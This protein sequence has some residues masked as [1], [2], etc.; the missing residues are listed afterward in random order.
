MSQKVN[1][2]EFVK[3]LQ[4]CLDT[5]CG[6]I[7]GSKG[8]DPKKW[9]KD[10]WWFTQ[11]EGTQREKALYW[12][13]HA[14]RVFDCNGL[15]EGY[16]EDC[17]GIDI[18]SKA[19]YNYSQW[20]ADCHGSDMS[21]LPKVPG[22]A[23]FIHSNSS[24]YITHVGYL[25]KPVSADKPNGDWYVIE[26]RGVMYGVVR[27]KL[28]QRGWNRWG[29]MLQYMDYG[30]VSVPERELGAR[31]LK[32]GMTGTDVRTL[33]SLLLELGYE[34]PRY[35][36]DGQYGSETVNAVKAFQKWAGLSA[37][38]E[39]GPDTHKALMLAIN[40]L[41]ADEDGSSPEDTDEQPDSST[42]PTVEIFADGRWNVRSGPGA[43][44]SVLTVV[45]A[46]ERFEHVATAYNGWLC[47]KLRDAVGW[48]SYKCGKVI[49]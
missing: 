48:V 15:M 4:K 36:A 18:N 43:E 23:V 35:G 3:F 14:P 25:E 10:S 28:S 34:L 44:Y 17:T 45:S 37:D 22:A 6:Y 27:T 5:G 19:R 38:G 1:S 41:H 20:C 49:E 26:A 7:M 42:I 13:E 8:Q 33:Q 32:S 11:Y 12:R 31:I 39:Y 30:D 9:A 29:L 2:V 21:E 46:G 24:G 40:E 16:Y 47:V